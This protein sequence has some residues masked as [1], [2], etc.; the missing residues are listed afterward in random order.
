MLFT[1]VFLALIVSVLGLD[2]S[3]GETVSFELHV[4]TLTAIGELEFGPDYCLSTP[5]TSDRTRISISTTTATAIASPDELTRTRYVS[6]T[7]V[8]TVFVSIT[9][10]I[11]PS[12][13]QPYI[14]SISTAD[15]STTE[16]MLGTAPTNSTR[17]GTISFTHSPVPT[18]LVPVIS[19][20]SSLSQRAWH[21]I[22]MLVIAFSVLFF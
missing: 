12:T 8:Q 14:T 18:T 6:E 5:V 17:V 15:H 4:G 7:I 21:S 22:T 11:P 2:V 10:P 1:P 3:P 19:G 16:T 9:G 13:S 20:G